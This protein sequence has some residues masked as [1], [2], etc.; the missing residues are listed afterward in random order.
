LLK[1]VILALSVMEEVVCGILIVW[2]KCLVAESDDSIYAV[3]EK[4]HCMV[5]GE[6]CCF[7]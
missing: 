5:N 7:S 3:A 1:D 6:P 2:L 4:M